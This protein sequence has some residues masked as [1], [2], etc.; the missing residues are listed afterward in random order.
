M[1][2]LEN[3]VPSYIGHPNIIFVINAETVWHDKQILTPF[4]HQF[5]A[6]VVKHSNGCAFYRGLW[7]R[8]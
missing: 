6:T 4:G 7:K 8:I 5:A 1:G 2:K 3:L